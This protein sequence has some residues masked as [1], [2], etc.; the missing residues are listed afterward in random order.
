MGRSGTS[1]QG[2]GR[3]F[4][5]VRL[6]GRI[7]TAYAVLGLVLVGYIASKIVRGG[8]YQEVTDGWLVDGIEL[9]GA[10]LCLAAGLRRRAGRS[11]AI[12]LGCALL[13]WSLGD[14]VLT[15]ESLG[16]AT[17]PVPSPADALYLTFFPL[18]YVAVVLLIR[19][20]SARLG[21]AAWL[22]GA[23]AGLGAAAV[24]AGFAFH[25]IAQV[26]GGSTS[27]VAVN[28]AYPIGDVMLLFLVIGAAAVLSGRNKAPW[29]LLAV[30]SACNVA[31]DTFNLFGSSVGSS[32]VGTVV[33]AVAWPI[34]IVLISLAVW[35]PRGSSS[36][37][38]ERKPSGFLL[39]GAGAVA[40]LTILVFAT[41]HD[42]SHVAVALAAATL[43][44]AGVRLA[45]TAR[46]LRGLTHTRYEQ[47]VTDHLT[48]LGNRRYL[49]DVL[50]RF[51]APGADEAASP[52]M[53]FLFVDLNRFKELN[54]SF[55][56]PAGDEVLRQ[57]GARLRA[58]LRETDA[59]IRLGGDEFAVLLLDVDAAYATG[60]AERLGASLE[61]PFQLDAVCP[62]IS[63]SIGIALTPG[64][65]DDSAG[66][67]WCA[68]V[69]MYRAKAAGMPFARYDQREDFDG[70]GN[71]LRLAEE[72]REAIEG[73][74]LLLY[75]QPQL[76]LGGGEICAVE[77]LLRWPHPRLGMVPPLRFLPVAEEA[78]LMRSLTAWVLDRS[79]AQCARWR[80]EG[81][82]MSVAVNV[83]AS[84]LLESD[85]TRVVLEA[86]ERHGLAPDA[87]IIELTETSIIKD[88][89]GS[90]RVIAELQAGGIIVSIDD[91]GAGF[92]SLA[93]LG[94][95]AVGEL[96]LDR[97]FVTRLGTDDPERGRQLVRATIE[98]G[99][100]LGMRVV[101]EG[102]EDDRTLVLLADLG[103]DIAQGYFIDVPR[104]AEDLECLRGGADGSA[105]A[106]ASP[107]VDPGRP[108]GAKA[109]SGGPR[110]VP[111]R[112]GPRRGSPTTSAR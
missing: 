74:E 90:K 98:L 43:L 32:H 110:R 68:D 107:A 13:C 86:L 82:N 15:I 27:E 8:S 53:A 88:F 76:G 37:L 71:R 31:G 30:G 92:T 64:D 93:Y 20:E 34:S 48:G 40:G 85:F 83:S 16:G 75:Y 21:L 111:A 63:A 17:P 112:G 23:V 52:R 55:G 26:A 65:A 62:R 35:L 45:L 89:V 70:G 41:L 6:P 39:P 2:G 81:L 60:V 10:A 36:P 101:A 46:S 108:R 11:V 9:A 38:T 67:V 5:R 49:F 50:D 61:E 103:C 58:C 104:P 105:P 91:F 56:H 97:T 84:N 1:D 59:L 42:A 28:L 109:A 4:S 100:A 77:A 95:L 25:S 54:D 18:A 33:N 94:A 80:G 99:H 73:D 47:S 51:F 57:V 12:L 24:C 72:L 78:G 79:L 7:R 22:D 96:K 102:V 69:A 29:V 19:G 106:G 44:V 3:T 66:L 14:V 87:L